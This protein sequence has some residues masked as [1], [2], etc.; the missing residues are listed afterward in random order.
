[1]TLSDAFLWPGTKAC[2]RLGLDPEADAGLIRWFFNTLFYLVI[3]LVIVWIIV[4]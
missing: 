1:M 2:E 4:A 3:G